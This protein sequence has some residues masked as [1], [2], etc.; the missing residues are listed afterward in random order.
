MGFSQA[1]SGLSAAA[2][3]LDV[4]GNNIANSQTVGFKG[5]SVQFSDVY[6]GAQFGLGT[7]V[8]A[9]LQDFSDGTLETTNRNMDLAISGNGFFRFEQNEQVVYSRNGQLTVSNDGYLVNA[10]GGQLTGYPADV[11]AGGNPQR[12]KVPAGALQANASTSI[13]ASLNLDAGSAVIDRNTVPFDMADSSSYSYANSGIVYDSL[14]HTHNVT[15]YFTRTGDSQWEVRQARG[16]EVAT[17]TG[18][19]EFNKDGTLASAT[20][21]EDFTFSP[22]GGAAELKLDLGFAGSTQFGNDFELNSLTQD[23]FSS[24]SLVGVVIDN[25]GNVVG[26]Y[27]NEQSKVLGTI[28]LASFNNPEGLTPVGDNAWAETNASGAALMGLA[29]AG[30]FGSIEAGAVETSNVDLTS[31]LVKLIIAQRNY[32]ANSQTIKTQDE[33]LQASINL[34]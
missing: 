27:S 19:L 5:A 28:V 15:L 24:G 6:A 22:G 9:V 30:L 17:Q 18:T 31:E 11:G 33:V 4:I 26:N 13:Q 21:M 20:G 25:K 23:G 32:Q 1:L 10:Q 3:N 34:R 8:S 16:S 2:T 7:K 29:G 12:L 14:G